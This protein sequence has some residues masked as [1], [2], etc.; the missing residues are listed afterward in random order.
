MYMLHITGPNRE[1]RVDHKKSG[2]SKLSSWSQPCV[3]CHD[4]IM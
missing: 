2:T 3:M 1:H 4:T